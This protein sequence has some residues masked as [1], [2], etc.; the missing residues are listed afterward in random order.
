M[1]EALKLRGLRYIDTT[2]FESF[3][4]FSQ[5]S[6]EFDDETSREARAFVSPEAVRV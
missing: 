4:D 6:N 3:E 5:R 1:H 2:V